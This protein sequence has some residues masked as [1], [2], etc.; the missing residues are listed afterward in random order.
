MILTSNYFLT[1][2]YKVIFTRLQAVLNG[3]IYIPNSNHFGYVYTVFIYTIIFMFS[4]L[5]AQST[6]QTRNF[7]EIS[8]VILSVLIYDAVYFLTTGLFLG[9][10]VP[11]ISNTSVSLIGDKLS[12]LN[13][14]Y[15]VL[16]T[17]V[18][19]TGLFFAGCSL[20]EK[21]FERSI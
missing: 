1:Y 11:G 14:V 18:I 9:N 20:Y 16:I 2:F 19:L 10:L 15:C 12:G 5:A 13:L 17:P 7:P 3:S 4:Y 6:P 21:H 8:A